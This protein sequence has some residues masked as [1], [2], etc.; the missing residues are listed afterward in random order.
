MAQNN[1]VLMTGRHP[2]I[3]SVVEEEEDEIIVPTITFEEK[4]ILAQRWK[5]VRNLARM[6]KFKF[7]SN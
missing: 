2:H 1:K 3:I 4:R 6:F 7:R 5:G